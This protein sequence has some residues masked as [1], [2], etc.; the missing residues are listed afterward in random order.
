MNQGTKP[1][2]KPKKNSLSSQHLKTQPNNQ[3]TI[4]QLQITQIKPKVP[5]QWARTSDL[6]ECFIEN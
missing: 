4:T 1:I 5:M 6:V 3:M 2:T